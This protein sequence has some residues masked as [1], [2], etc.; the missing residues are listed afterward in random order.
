MAASSI[1]LLI[2]SFSFSSV[3][4]PPPLK[5]SQVCGVAIT[6]DAQL[7]L[8]PTTGNQAEKSV[9]TDKEGKFDFGRVPEGAY[10][11]SVKWPDEKGNLKGPISNSYPIAVV[12]SKDRN[13]CQ[14]PLW[15]GVL[16]GSESGITV[17][18]K[19]EKK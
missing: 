15:V 4:D 17:S 13:S 9:R 6:A 2:P 10:R 1:L 12:S 16:S 11:L 5:V 19:S 14:R 8:R 3:I 7:T 18:F